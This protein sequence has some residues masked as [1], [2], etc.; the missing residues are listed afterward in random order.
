MSDRFM[1]ECVFLPY[2][3]SWGMKLSVAASVN[4][5]VRVLQPWCS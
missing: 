5:V 1:P 2:R 3:F 4:A